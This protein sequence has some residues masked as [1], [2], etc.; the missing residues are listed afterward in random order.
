MND[1]YLEVGFK[2]PSHFST[3]FKKNYGFAPS[4]I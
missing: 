2:N 4:E 3:A 1:V